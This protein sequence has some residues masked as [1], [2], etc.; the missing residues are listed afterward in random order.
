MQTYHFGWESERSM[1]L[2]ILL[3]ALALFMLAFVGLNKLGPTVFG[4]AA[5]LGLLF[6]IYFVWLGFTH[7]NENSFGWGC[8]L[9]LASGGVLVYLKSAFSD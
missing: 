9:L 8:L 5:V 4:L 7:S 6:G 3:V 1:L 2:P